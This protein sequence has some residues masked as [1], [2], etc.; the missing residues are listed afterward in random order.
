MYNI[1]IYYYS[2]LLRERIVYI[3]EK[4]DIYIYYRIDGY[5]IYNNTFNIN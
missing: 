4:G 1:F 3:L 5:S 2:H